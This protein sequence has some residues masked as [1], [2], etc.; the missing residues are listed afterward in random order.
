M[1][2]G[3]PAPSGPGRDAPGEPLVAP[4]PSPSGVP[5]AARYWQARYSST[6]R[7]WGDGPSELARLAVARLRPL[8]SPDLSVVDLGCGYGRDSIHLAAELGC[9]VHGIDPAPAA[10][11]DAAA[12]APAGLHL[13]FEAADA[14]SFAAAAPQGF[15]V[16]YTCNVYHLL[17]PE[18]RRVFA[19]AAARLARAGALLFLSTLAPGDPQHWGVGDPVPN[20]RN[21]WDDHVY[22]HFVTG[23]ELGRDFASFEILDLAARTYDEHNADGVVHRHRSWFLVGRRRTA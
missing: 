2:G 1:N 16:V 11:A 17:R 3:P 18:A 14:A 19:A 6:G 21:S 9:R 23:D 8:A 5:E 20:E 15:D 12:A 22:L 4:A 7:V 10:V 13:T